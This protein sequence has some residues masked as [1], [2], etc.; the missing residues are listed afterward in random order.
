MNRQKNSHY[1][2]THNLI[3]QTMVRLLESM[4]LQD[5]T[6][7]K[8]CAVAGINR[9]T[10]YEHY[11]S[12]YL[13]MDDIDSILRIE[14]IKELDNAHIALDNFLSRDGLNVVLKFIYRYKNFYSEYLTI[15]SA[16]EYI[17]EIFD[18]LVKNREDEM[19]FGERTYSLYSY[20]FSI[21]GAMKV[22]E[23]WMKHGCIEPTEV[24]ANIIS[25]H[26]GSS[27]SSAGTAIEH[28]KP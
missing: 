9:S 22:V 28:E 19:P 12:I 26:L 27:R 25:D 14:H 16:S 4:P 18:D 2:Y 10:F 7:K 20:L 13:L 15:E 17:E 3:Q 24:I 23:R 5:I 1:V 21:G 8:L 11:E 6:V